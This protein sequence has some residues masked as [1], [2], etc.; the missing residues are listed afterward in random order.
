MLASAPL[1][2]GVGVAPVDGPAA[3]H[4]HKLPV[5]APVNQPQPD[6]PEGASL[7]RLA[8]Q[9]PK[10]NPSCLLLLLLTM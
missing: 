5:F 8:A 4:A 7:T 6:L 10:Q 9:R 1:A 2:S 3:Q